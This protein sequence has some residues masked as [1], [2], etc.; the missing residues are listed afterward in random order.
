MILHAILRGALALL[1]TSGAALAQIGQ[2]PTPPAGVPGSLWPFRTIPA[3]TGVAATD[4]AN[5]QAALTL[6]A[7]GTVYAANGN[8]VINSTEFISS[9]TKLECA[10]GAKF[11]SAAAWAGGLTKVLFQNVNAG[12]GSITD[13]DIT[14]NGC[15]FD[16]TNQSGNGFFSVNLRQARHLQLSSLNCTGG[17][18]CTALQA[19]DDAEVR[20]SSASLQE[21]ACWDNWEAPT[22]GRIL[23]NYCTIHGNYGILV[24]G[25]NT[26][27]DLVGI[28]KDYVVDGNTIVTDATAAQAGIWAQGLG[29]AGAGAT[30]VK[31][32][33]NTI[34]SSAS[35]LVAAI[36]VSGA[37]VDNEIIA[38]TIRGPGSAVHPAIQT[39]ADAGGT[40]THTVVSLGHIVNYVSTGTPLISLAGTGDYVGAV[41]VIGG[42]FTYAISLAG[43]NQSADIN[44]LLTPGSLGYYDVSSAVNPHMIGG[45]GPPRRAGGVYT[46]ALIVV[47]ATASPASANKVYLTKYTVRPFDPPIQS[48]SLN[49][50]ANTGGFNFRFC[51]Y[52]DQGGTKPG[53]APVVDSGSIA[54][55]AA[56]VGVQTYTPGSPIILAPGDYWFGASLDSVVE[57]VTEITNAG[58][59]LHATNEAG[60]T[61]LA[62]AFSGA[63]NSS[64]WNATATVSSACPTA[65]TFAQTIGSQPIVGVTY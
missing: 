49:V 3:A 51:V 35:S 45:D 5:V 42:T 16:L 19:V 28:A 31:I 33:N 12:A 10:P 8:Y 30:N 54:V 36:K 32:I 7:G 13:Q 37:G 63:S 34:D 53:S 41:T 20:N 27:H 44:N 14:I 21:N 23:H 61:S 48:L 24:T 55:T 2:G 56:T 64:G 52:A 18:D 25:T 22:H 11:T 40:P 50:V 4:T 58:S 46:P 62:N 6:A 65:P 43:S 38:N 47:P 59:I 15:A 9:S 17:S 29:V 60:Q 39:V 57:T 1:L 26:A